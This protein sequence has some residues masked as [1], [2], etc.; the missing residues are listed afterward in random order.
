MLESVFALASDSVWSSAVPSL[1]GAAI[2]MS[3]A[4]FIV[5]RFRLK[6]VLVRCISAWP[7]VG[8]EPPKVGS[9]DGL[10]VLVEK[11]E[12]L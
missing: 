10:G 7:N 11:Q 9:N 12:G 8:V 4:R 1:F 2:E 3:V 5:R 6:A